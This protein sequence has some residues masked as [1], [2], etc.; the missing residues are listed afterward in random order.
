MKYAF[1]LIL[2]LL[3]IIS[4]LH[5]TVI[6]PRV[7]NGQW[8]SADDQSLYYFQDGLIYCSKH[9]VALSDRDS[10]SGAY[11]YSRNSILLFAA[12]VEG[13]ETEKEIYLVSNED[14]SFLCEHKDGTG[15]IYFIR[16][17]N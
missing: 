1:A 13:L 11:C 15:A 2:I 4:G 12:G 7:Y 16:Y 3:V 14:G 5:Q 6:D 10:I 8:Y 17:Q 9:A